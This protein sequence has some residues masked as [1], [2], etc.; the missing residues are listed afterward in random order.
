MKIKFKCGSCNWK[1]ARAQ[2][3]NMCPYCGKPSVVEDVTQ[4]ADDLLREFE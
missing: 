2:K 1:F 3:P 4:A